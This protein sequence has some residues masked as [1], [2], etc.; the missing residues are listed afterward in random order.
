MEKLIELLNEYEKEKEYRDYE[1]IIER[2][3]KE[4]MCWEQSNWAYIDTEEMERI[5][6]SKKYWF[7]K[8]LVDNDKI[9]LLRLDNRIALSEFNKVERVLMF[10]SI[11]DNPI[12][13]LCSV[14]K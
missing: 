13:F 10:L 4:R 7:I 2:K 1:W 3:N 11:Q 9:D 5:I 8:W 14:L 6:I 12:E